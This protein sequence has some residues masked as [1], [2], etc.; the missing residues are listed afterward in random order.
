MAH[1]VQVLHLVG[2]YLV[3]LNAQKVKIQFVR[4]I[5]PHP[6]RKPGGELWVCVHP[7]RLYDDNSHVRDIIWHE[8]LANVPHARKKSIFLNL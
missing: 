8:T 1:R 3:G 5:G 4:D 7:L 6:F 2:K